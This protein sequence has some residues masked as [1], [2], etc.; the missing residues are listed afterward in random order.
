MRKKGMNILCGTI[1]FVVLEFTARMDGHYTFWGGVAAGVLTAMLVD[2]L[3]D[4][5]K[6]LL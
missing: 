3:E 5:R 4:N 1:A 6:G 2:I